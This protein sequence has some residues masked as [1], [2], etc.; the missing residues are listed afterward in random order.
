MYF[1]FPKL[2]ALSFK[3]IYIYTVYIYYIVIIE[4]F[5][6]DMKNEILYNNI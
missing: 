1:H 6:Y 5:L 2:F 4:Q 3:N